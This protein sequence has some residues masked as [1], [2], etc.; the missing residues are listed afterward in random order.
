MPIDLTDIVNGDGSRGFVLRGNTKLD[1]SGSSI[2][3]AGD[4]NGDGFDD[5]IV[6]APFAG[7]ADVGTSYVVFGK[8]G[9]FAATLDLG[10]I[11][12]G[13][14]TQGF[15]ILGEDVAD[16]AGYSVSSAGDLNGDGYGDLI[17]GAPAGNGAING[18][19]AGAFSYVIFGKGSG[20]DKS[21][22]LA[23]ITKGNGS[24]GFTLGGDA[25]TS[26]GPSVSLAGDVNG[27]GFD[28]VIVGFPQE[29]AAGVGVSYVVFGK[30]GGFG[31]TF[32]LDSMSAGSGVNGFAIK[33]EQAGDQ[34]GFSVASAG[35]VNGDGFDDLIVGARLGDGPGD[36]RD[37][38]GDSY[39]V[40]GKAG[41]FG[42]TLDLADIAKGDGSKGF[43]L[44]GE[45]AGDHSGFSVASAGDVNG[46]G[47]DDLIV[48]AKDGDGPAD[49]RANAGDS[50]VVFG[51][52]GGF[53]ATF[54]L[55]AIT[56]G[57]GSLGFVLH[58][59]QADDGS[60]LSV[61]SAGDV[62][63]DGIDD[64]IV[65]AAQVD[66]P[67][68]ARENSGAAYVVFGKAGAFDAPLDLA[69][70]AAGDGSKGFI[71]YGRN[72]LDGAG[73]SVSSAGDVN[74]DGFD[75]LM[76]GAPSAAVG[77][78]ETYV[79]FGSATI[80]G[81]TSQ[82]TQPAGGDA[83]DTLAGTAGADVLV[84][85]R[86]GDTLSGGGGADSL[87]GGEGDDT[88][89]INDANFVHLDGG[90]GSDTLV[91]AGA[92][93]LV[94]SN[95]R[96]VSDMEGIALGAQAVNLTLGRS[97][98]QAFG[99]VASTGFG[100]T[101]DT[102]ASSSNAAQVINAAAFNHGLTVDFSKNTVGV[103]VGGGLRA[104]QLTGGSGDDVLDGGGGA[105]KLIGGAGNDTYYVTTGDVV[106]E[107]VGGG[108]DRVAVQSDFVLSGGQEVEL[109]TTTNSNAARSIDIRGNE[110]AQTIVGNEGNNWLHDGGVGGADTLRGG[111]GNDYYTVYNSDAVII[112]SKGQGDYDRLAA[113]VD[114]ELA[115]GV[116]IES[117]RTTNQYATYSIDLT[118]NEFGQEIVGNDGV[119]RID[120]K[121]GADTIE[122]GLGADTLH[123]GSGNDTIYGGYGGR[124]AAYPV[125]AKG[126]GNVTRPTGNLDTLDV[127]KAFNLAANPD[128]VDST[129]TPHVTINARG[130]DN[131]HLYRVD[132]TAG[133]VLTLD[134]DATTGGLNTRISLLTSNLD[135]LASNDDSGF[136]VPDSGSTGDLDS[137]LTYTV[138]TGGTYYI[139]VLGKD[140]PAWPGQNYQ[141]HISAAGIRPV[142]SDNDSL[143][144]DSG[145]DTLWGGGGDDLLDGGAGADTMHGGTG[146]DMFIVDN[147][148]DV[149]IEAA[150]EGTADRVS[151]RA[152]YALQA[153]T[154]I[155]LLTTT[156]FAGTAAINLT[157]NEFAQSIVGNAGANIL[158]GGG[159]NDILNG[160]GGNDTLYG[161]EG[162]DTIAGGDGN[163]TL[164][165]GGG[166][167]TMRGGDGD[168]V[169]FVDAGDVVFEASGG[170]DDRV[171]TRT[172]FT[173]A[174]GQEIEVLTT[175]DPDGTGAIALTGNEFAQTIIGNDGGN[176]LDD[177]GA[178]GIDTLV[179]KGGND[180]YTIHNSSAVIV[181]AKG[182][183]YD[184]VSTS[185]DYVLAQGVEVESLRT[186]SQSATYNRDLTGNEFGQEIIGNNGVNRIDGKGGND[187]IE[188]ALGNDTLHGGAGN[189]TIYGELAPAWVV[190]LGSGSIAKPP[191]SNTIDLDNA[192]SLAADPDIVDSETVPH[193]TVS[194][195]GNG[196]YHWYRVYLSDRA[197]LTL[198]IDKTT[199]GLDSGI[200]LYNDR[201]DVIASNN[202][203]LPTQGAGGSASTLDSF[204]THTV[205][206]GGVYTIIVAQG[207]GLSP[208]PLGQDYQLHVSAAEIP[209]A[210][211][212]LSNDTLFG[213]SGNDTLFG[214]GG[215]DVLDGGADA[216]M[217]RGGGGKDVFVFS[218]ALGAGNVDTILDFNVADDTI[219]LDHT[220]FTALAVGALDASAFK[221]NVLAPIDADDR[222][223]YN[224][225]TGSLFYYADGLGGAAEV[226]F[227][228]LLP[229]LTLTAADFLVI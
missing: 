36:S 153:G 77:A 114:Y 7:L 67:A 11:A 1:Q 194:A 64:L 32:L 184:R 159:G 185:V 13:D 218:T 157:G 168:D 155:E 22:D 26:L 37:A 115:K 169:F 29:R 31:P 105:D 176:R 84:G 70:I 204:L 54:D 79:I 208:I 223:L 215:D 75:D 160:G 151:A 203:S 163:D 146:N 25:T 113:G 96:R 104:D 45:T 23:A 188:G 149:V 78:G 227:A 112:E 106:T 217:L 220:I 148:G 5:V 89:I 209:P 46:D 56:A 21:I 59:A 221:D 99:G 142:E 187:T 140:T 9:G 182:Q 40:F 10:A 189:D 110:L 3:S 39:V 131:P 68:G 52:Q 152:S 57:D 91:L 122:G 109:L 55:A 179:G 121:G 2:S 123:G 93:T 50:Y 38:A 195:A 191:G 141:L 199:G 165:G 58:G 181:E 213:D 98:S 88:L 129:Y 28:D 196:Q 20:F 207:D 61:S 74:G 171:S 178:K 133:A 197:T 17:V 16:G 8:A 117:I 126:S 134:I 48:G 42:G 15:A 164:D 180:F 60:G 206:R 83:A 200:W 65:G 225:D 172:D 202:D 162:D 175:A 85:G 101:I 161:G 150:G 135:L 102:T 92:M 145:D 192:F 107:A 35:D 66:G 177:G 63:G 154:E 216:D 73:S 137:F 34:S 166:T 108:S 198:D 12:T 27:D 190:G 103:S 143:Y 128:V 72:I 80:G 86:D 193:V 214:G 94:D 158:S 41:G 95:F 4:V 19:P 219:R 136:M 130:D 147:A 173:L 229:G 174:A 100:V 170:G 210:G 62:N 76:V 127:S 69:D 14:G 183:G 205:D 226:K 211:I 33:G 186:T 111:G 167:D 24:Q 47:I 87:R 116:E 132:L 82:L 125:S 90:N 43:V 224:S 81:S 49:G 71:I 138:T 30:A 222:I 44:R 120:G 97:A 139:A 124:A 118:G 201:L 51:R 18:T 156:S 228:S 6:G 53:A 119:N 212:E 144:G